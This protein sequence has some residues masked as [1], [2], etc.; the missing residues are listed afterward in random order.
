MGGGREQEADGK[1]YSRDRQDGAEG[2]DRQSRGKQ[3][4]N[5]ES[6]RQEGRKKGGGRGGEEQGGEGGSGQQEQEGAT[7]RQQ[8]STPEWVVGIVCSIIV[9]GALGYLF[10]QALSSP[11]LPPVVTIRVERVLPFARGY[12]VEFTAMNEGSQT[13]VNLM[14]E[15]AL[16]RDTT[17]VEKSTATL[18][19]V[20]ARAERE[21][22]LIF[23]RDPRRYRL[24]VRPMGYD[25]P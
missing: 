17:A 23:T 25:R 9:L 7:E 13:A 12:V 1:G 21:G 8:P 16:M 14:V 3:R 10:Y 4:E 5:Q 2:D 19:F 22:G 15:G 11:S 18:D 20:P 6:D 24:E